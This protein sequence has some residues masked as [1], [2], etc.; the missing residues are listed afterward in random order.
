MKIIKNKDMFCVQVK[1]DSYNLFWN[2]SDNELIKLLG[3]IKI[4]E[5]EFVIGFIKD[6]KVNFQES[7]LIMIR[8]IIA[9]LNQNLKN[10]N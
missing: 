10:E 5:S 3:N 7:D 4:V 8:L 2:D 6:L 9:E 1:K